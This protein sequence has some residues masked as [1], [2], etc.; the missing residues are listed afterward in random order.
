MNSY[1]NEIHH[2]LR[3]VVEREKRRDG[4]NKLFIWITALC[5]GLFLFV[6]VEA[7]LNLDNSTRTALFFVW[8]SL[9]AIYLLAAIV[10][11]LSKDFYS[12]LK[13]NFVE[14]AKK[15]GLHFPE[16][17]D[18]LANAIQLLEQTGLNYSSQLVEAAFKRIYEKSSDINFTSIVDFSKTRK[19]LKLSVATLTF[20]L[21]SLFLIPGLSSAAY[22]FFNYEKDF[23]T[24]PAFTFRVIPGN[25]E[26]TKGENV[27]ISIKAVGKQ[28]AKIS[29]FTKTTEQT[30][31]SEIK[32][33]SDSLGNFNYEAVS[34]KSTTDYYAHADGITGET[35]RLSVINRPIISSLN[36][37]VV[38]PAYSKLP[39]F[40]QKDNGN[41]TALPGSKILLS[42]SASRELAK[43]KIIFSDSA[44]KPMKV[45]YANTSTELFVSK[46]MDY[47]I[48]ITDAQGFENSNPI[49]YSIKTLSDNPPGI[50]LISP[51]ANVNMGNETK[52]SLIS[53]ISDDYGFSQMQL[54]YKLSQSKYRQPE[55]NFTKLP[56]T[57]SKEKKE[58]DVYFVWDLASLY[59]AEGEALTFYLEIF[60][61]DNVNGPK[62]ARTESLT[63]TVPS[64]EQILAKSDEAQENSVKELTETLKEAE[65]L[66]QEMK[67]I[68]DDMKVNNREISWQEKERVEKA[69]EKFKQLGEKVEDISQKLSEMQKDLMK[70]S[71]LSEETLQKYNE[72]QELMNKFDSKELKDALSR[73]SE[74]LKNM[75]RDNVQMSMEEMKANEEYFK[76]SIERTLN[77]LK[78]IQAEQK[79]DE[80]IKRAEDISEKIDELKKQ[81]EQSNLNDSQ[82]QKELAKK[83]KDITESL[84]KFD[85]AMKDAQEK[86]NAL[87][88]LPKDEMQKLAEEFDK[89]NNEELSEEAMKDLQKMMKQQAMQSQQQLSG[90]MKNMKQQMKN[91]Q[92]AMQQMNQM[93]TFWDMAKILNDLLDLSKQQENLKNKTEQLSPYSKEFEKA[94][95]EQNKIQSSLNKVLQNMSTL[96]QKTFAITPEMGKA[97]GAALSEMQ[98]AISTM[99]TPGAQLAYRN[100]TN[101]MEQL[102]EAASMLKGGMDQL[103]QGGQ[104]GGMMSM[105]QQLQQMAQQQMSLNQLTQ[106]MNQ[107][108]LSQEMMSQMQR[109]AQQQEAIRKSLEQ[110]NQEAK[111]SGQ[112]KRL[113]SNLEKILSEMKE[114][115]TNLQS[116]KVDNELIKQQEKI[117]SKLIDAQRSVNER[118]F[119]KDRKSNTGENIARNTPPELILSTDEGK[120]KLRDELQKAIR[121][122]YKKDYEDLIRKYFES[123]LDKSNK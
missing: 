103:M 123:L 38:P 30:E 17:K 85:D 18:E 12:Y 56:I 45:N 86:M 23:S 108:K 76:K 20:T 37:T 117:L 32:L 112:S 96:S 98:Q 87:K 48:I 1:L 59:L 24:P 95:R 4:L 62:S 26:I 3:A 11:P 109:L 102:N 64:L 69:A 36:L 42:V 44:S 110:L 53:K 94:A 27:L 105:M 74:S 73:L 89:Q 119:E 34:L 41:V 82:K 66:Q 51:T 106:M 47:Q 75:M 104:S 40:T 111:Q 2:K 115:V 6:A 19:L 118:D 50:E 67:K 28:P 100:Q 58:D 84:E 83:Q 31:P 52:I 16:I 120:N 60:D 9:G 81:T 79:V 33:T 99:Q 54:N 91:M 70:N 71:L 63:I 68:S 22:R 21:I 80:L 113:A 97:L 13:P 55:D 122:G 43:A 121:E 39:S 72:L 7:L 116:E 14:T 35:Y 114:V 90:N 88:D 78:R 46:E 10:Y 25:K 107:G 93:K 8:I 65:R 61:N 15:V 57:I 92:S 77:L 29:L 5:V 49:S 101:A